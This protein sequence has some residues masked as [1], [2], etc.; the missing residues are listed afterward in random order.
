LS[1]FFLTP[2]FAWSRTWFWPLSSAA[3][4]AAKLGAMAP[5]NA[6][7]A[8]SW[9]AAA[10]PG[11]AKA[12]V[13]PARSKKHRADPFQ[14]RRVM[15]LRGG[16]VGHLGRPDSSVRLLRMLCRLGSGNGSQSCRAEFVL[17]EDEKA[18]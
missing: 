12:I 4:S 13:K 15:S 5:T 1:P 7:G 2:A 18:L 16:I 9:L 11:T 6:V 14:D 8:G 10:P 3:G 17:R